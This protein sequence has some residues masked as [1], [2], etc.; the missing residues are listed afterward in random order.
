MSTPRQADP[1]RLARKLYD[2]D[3]T[4]FACHDVL[5]LADEL[6]GRCPHCHVLI[7]AGPNIAPDRA[8]EMLTVLQAR[9]RALGLVGN[10]E[11]RSRS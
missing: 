9:R 8:G 10:P 2:Y 6:S 1:D 7:Q 3:R 4:C 5:S 11:R